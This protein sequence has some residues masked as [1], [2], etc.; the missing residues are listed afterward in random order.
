M[1][2]LAGLVVVQRL[3]EVVGV[4]AGEDRLVRRRGLVAVGAVAGGAGLRGL[5]LSRFVISPRLS[6]SGRHPVVRGEIG[7]V[8]VP[9]ARRDAAHRGM[10]AVA[11]LVSLQGA[12]EVGRLLAY[13]I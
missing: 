4:L 10:R 11:G 2:A 13:L 8:L 6:R 12:D 3:C 9:E 1:V 5:R 7:H